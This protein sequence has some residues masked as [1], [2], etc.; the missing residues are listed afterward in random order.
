MGLV[1]PVSLRA[2]PVDCATWAR[3][4]MDFLS[5]KFT[6]NQRS[7]ELEPVVELANHMLS[8]LIIASTS[9]HLLIYFVLGAHY[10]SQK[11]GREENPSRKYTPCP[12]YQ[13]LT[14]D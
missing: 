10:R 3:E 1:N 7:V 6:K 14:E 11:S 9:L 8:H 2:S 13:S 5:A 12:K 4:V